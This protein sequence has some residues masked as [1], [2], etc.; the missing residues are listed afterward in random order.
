MPDDLTTEF[1]GYLVTLRNTSTAL[2][3]DTEVA[4]HRATVRAAVQSDDDINTAY[5]LYIV[6]AGG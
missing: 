6:P 4:L 1:V 5:Q 3:M 2:D